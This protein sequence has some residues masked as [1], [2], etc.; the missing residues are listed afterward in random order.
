MTEITNMRSYKDLEDEI[1]GLRELVK[2]QIRF[3]DNIEKFIYNNC[4][5]RIYDNFEVIKNKFENNEGFE[6]SLVSK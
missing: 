6:D 5:V 1:T 4:D 3:I 2:K